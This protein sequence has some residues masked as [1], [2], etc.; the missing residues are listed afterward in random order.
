NLDGSAEGEATEAQIEGDAADEHVATRV[1]SDGGI[2]ELGE[3]ARRDL[4]VQPAAAAVEARVEPEHALGRPARTAWWQLGIVGAAH[5]VSGVRRIRRDRGLVVGKHR[6]VAV[7]HDVRTERR[8]GL[9]D[10]SE[11]SADRL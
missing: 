7:D 4:P 5:Q 2:V 10:G 1:E 11:R 6:A 8:R 3:L 9:A